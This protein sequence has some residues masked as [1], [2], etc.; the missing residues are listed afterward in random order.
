M[1]LVHLGAIATGIVIALG[2][3]MVL[4]AFTRSPS[5]SPPLLV[6]LSFS[7][8]DDSNAPDWCKDLASIFTRYGIKATVFVTGKVADQYPECV[9]VFSNNIDIGSQTYDYVDL[10]KI[11]DY[12]AQFE[13]VRNGKQ[14]VDYAGKLYSQVFKAPYGSTDGNTYSLLSRSDIVADFSYEQQY[15]KYYNGQ[16][17]KFDLTAYE[18]RNHSGGF[19]HGLSVTETPTL[20]SFDNSTPTEQIDSFIS[21]LKSGNVRFVNASELTGIDLTIREGERP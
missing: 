19:F 13:E 7:V 8:T 5:Y 18:G 2:I 14:A 10:T 20:I 1:K 6:M 11:P 4:P 15:N 17:I 12:T 16:F 21:E 3:V 9:R